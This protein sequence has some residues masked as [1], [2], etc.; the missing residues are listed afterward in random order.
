MIAPRAIS[1][2]RLPAI[3]DM[4]F[5]AARD[6]FNLW[7]RALRIHQ[8]SKN[9]LLF[10]PG[11]LS[12]RI[13]E[14]NVLSASALAFLAFSL[15]TSG[16]YVLND[17][18]DMATDRRHPRK[19]HR[20]FAAGRLTARSGYAALF[21]LLLAAICLAC[22]VGYPFAA[23][24]CGYYFITWLYTLRLKYIALVD[25]MKLAALYTLRII[26][27]SAAT[28]IPVSF[29]LLAFSMFIFLSLAVAKRYAEVN[30]A[31]SSDPASISPRGYSADDLP[32]LL[33][34]GVAAGYCMVVVMA[35][36]INSG[37]SLLLYQNRQPLWLVCLLLLFWISRM[38]LLTTRG[39]MPDDPV[40]FAL[41]DLTSWMVLALIALIV[42]LAL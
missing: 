34:T 28:T 21:T 41:R 22:T 16:V 5:P 23:V 9:A 20:P 17:L 24:L 25:V 40:A 11:L 14:S 35:V 31:A 6:T 10:L 3:A 37:D 7:M 13:L 33:A 27:G 15:C 36:Y 30:E 42:L 32:F 29:W 19:R 8:W 12:H 26:A 38:W 39:K 2:P 4:S 1:R 18:H